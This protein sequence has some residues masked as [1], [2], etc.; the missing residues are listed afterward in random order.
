MR[1]RLEDQRCIQT[2]SLSQK[3]KWELIECARDWCKGSSLNPN[4][5]S[6]LSRET[7]WTEEPD[8]NI[9]PCSSL[10][11]HLGEYIPRLQMCSG[12]IKLTK[13]WIAQ[14]CLVMAKVGN[15]IG[16]SPPAQRPAQPAQSE[17]NQH[18]IMMQRS[19]QVS[20]KTVGKLTSAESDDKAHRV[21]GYKSGRTVQHISTGQED[22][23]NIE[24]E[25]SE[26]QHP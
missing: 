15:S 12:V 16:V 20:V 22:Q 7:E 4:H 8:L 18:L 25:K 9:D 2:I 24:E 26:P 10:N 19:E 5:I 11:G 13:Y 23:L 3:R 14:V 6:S 17:R 21:C 1:G